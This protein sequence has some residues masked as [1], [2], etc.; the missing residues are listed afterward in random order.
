MLVITSA[1]ETQQLREMAAVSIAFGI[2]E[3]MVEDSGE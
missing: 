2:R 3:H 1:Q